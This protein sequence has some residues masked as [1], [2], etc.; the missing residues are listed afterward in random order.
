MPDSSRTPAESPNRKVL[1]E[2]PPSQLNQI[3]RRTGTPETKQDTRART[4]FPTKSAHVLL[5]SPYGVQ[6]D[7]KQLGELTRSDPSTPK[8]EENKHGPGRSLTYARSPTKTI[9]TKRSVS[10]LRSLYENQASSNSPPVNSPAHLVGS[11][12]PHHTKTGSVLEK[13]EST[14]PPPLPSTAS[15]LS[16]HLPHEQSSFSIRRVISEDALPRWPVTP[17]DHSELDFLPAEGSPSQPVS[18][19]RSS[20][21]PNLVLCERAR[22]DHQM[23][24]SLP[25]SPNVVRLAHAS[26]QSWQTESTASDIDSSSRPVS[27]NFRIDI[28]SPLQPNLPS[29]QDYSN[30]KL[31]DYTTSS[32][33]NSANWET[34]LPA[35]VD[36]VLCHG[37][38]LDVPLSTTPTPAQHQTV[39][40]ELSPSSIVSTISTT[41]EQPAS[42]PSLPVASR[43]L[44]PLPVPFSQDLLHGDVQ[45]SSDPS[46]ASD[47]HY[48]LIPAP[49]RQSWEELH[50][51][52][53]GNPPSFDECQR[54]RWNPHLSM[55]PSELSWGP[56]QPSIDTGGSWNQ[57]GTGSIPD[58]LQSVDFMGEPN[59]DPTMKAGVDREMAE[60]SDIISDLRL[61]QLHH[62]PSGL[63][64]ASLEHSRTNSFKSLVLRSH[65]SNGS[66]QTAVRFPAWA[67]RYYS[68]GLGDTLISSRPDTANSTVSQLSQPATATNRLVEQT[69]LTLSHSH[70]PDVLKPCRSHMLPGSGPPVSH[71]G[72]LQLSSLPHDLTDPRASW[73]AQK[74][75]SVNTISQESP[76]DASSAASDWSPHLFPDNQVHHRSHWLAP[77]SVHNNERIFSHRNFYAVSFFLGFM[78]PVTWFV[79]AILPLP[80]QPSTKEKAFDPEAG[81]SDPA[82]SQQLQYHATIAKEVRY[83]NVRWWRNLNRF[84]CVVGVLI[85]VVVVSLY[86]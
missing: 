60:A 15:S 7:N 78:C 84:M 43:P 41:L 16:T 10:E 8:Y 39:S 24:T 4:P 66:L 28:P 50:V 65:A 59:S 85:V 46:R 36:G 18:S 1:Q 55:V 23:S 37:H 58:S 33:P 5:P 2:R 81:V 80:A 29:R 6:R 77:P 75:A 53:R 9:A 56:S 22:I 57:P 70:A 30:P 20:S 40:F 86:R 54:T 35:G 63:L 79:A 47:M 62:K 48:P 49:R 13:T 76:S 12:L 27:S 31:K 71:P 82:F 52:K 42:S 38:Q 64:A 21:D 67:C 69:I 32:S 19:Q 17:S 11:P 73:V 26:S 61:P 44:P 83:A 14:G 25:S 74:P 68:R 51:L 34:S 3:S 72:E 45:V